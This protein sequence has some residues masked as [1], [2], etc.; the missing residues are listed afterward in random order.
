MVGVN[1]FELHV[2]NT[3]DLETAR[4]ADTIF[5]KYGNSIYIVYYYLIDGT[6]VVITAEKYLLGPLLTAF[7]KKNITHNNNYEVISLN[8][9]QMIVKE[10]TESNVCYYI[11][12][13]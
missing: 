5:S 11:L 2:D 7:K 12:L 4:V 1:I 10:Y 8:L 9:D 13:L 3:T 6:A